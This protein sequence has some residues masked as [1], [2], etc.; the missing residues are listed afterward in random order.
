LRRQEE[1]ARSV[2]LEAAHALSATRQAAAQRLSSQVSEAMQELSMNG[3]R[4]VVA[5][6]PCEPAA[7]GVEQVEFL[8]AGHA[9][10]PDREDVQRRVERPRHLVRH[11]DTSAGQSDDDRARVVQVQQLLRQLLAGVQS[12]L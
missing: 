12:H 2:Y 9:E 8:V 6:N 11:L 7:Y 5:L 3:G 4:F 1:K 10:L